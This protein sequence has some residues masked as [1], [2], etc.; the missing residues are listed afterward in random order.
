[1][2]SQVHKEITMTISEVTKGLA[3][4][5]KASLMQTYKANLADIEE[6]KAAI[7]AITAANVELK[8]AYDSLNKDIPE[9]V[10]GG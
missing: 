3:A 2:V 7:K 10:S 5:Q 9:P 4:Q 8:A 1:M 6:H